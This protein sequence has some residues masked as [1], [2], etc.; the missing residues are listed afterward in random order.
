MTVN[1]KGPFSF[2]DN[3]RTELD[4]MFLY[5]VKS[6]PCIEECERNRLIFEHNV[7]LNKEALVFYVAVV[8]DTT[9]NACH[10]QN[11]AS[12]VAWHAK[13]HF[14]DAI[15][16]HVP[17]LLWKRVLHCPNPVEVMTP[18]DVAIYQRDTALLT[19]V[20]SLP[21]MIQYAATQPIAYV[22]LIDRGLSNASKWAE[23]DDDDDETT[24]TIIALLKEKKCAPCTV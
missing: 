1:K 21:A 10:Y 6:V 18:L 19:H 15:A 2:E 8:R 14:L 7:I 11:L 13:Y 5:M 24:R 16:K 17:T 23:D 9:N 4:E 3:M 12:V 22:S 20:L